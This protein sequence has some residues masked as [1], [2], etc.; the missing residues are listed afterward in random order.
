M[1]VEVD[2]G[3]LKVITLWSFAMA[4]AGK[5]VCQ[6]MTSPNAEIT[7]IFI[8]SSPPNLGFGPPTMVMPTQFDTAY[9]ALCTFV[10]RPSNASIPLDVLQHFGKQNGEL[11]YELL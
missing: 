8:L 3:V 6:L 1:L 11:G 4:D 9:A 2:A 5:E 7:Y 10:K